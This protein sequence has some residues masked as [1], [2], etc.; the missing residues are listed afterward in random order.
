MAHWAIKWRSET[1]LNGKTSHFMC[2]HSGLPMIFKTKALARAFMSRSVV[3]RI[4]NAL[5]VQVAVTVKEISAGVTISE[6]PS[7]E[8]MR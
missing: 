7:D 6:R 2:D 4:R 5:P 3:R 8:T 1:R